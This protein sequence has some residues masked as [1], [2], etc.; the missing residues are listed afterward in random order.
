[1][2]PNVIIGGPG[3]A[4]RRAEG[5]GVLDGCHIQRPAGE[6]DAPPLVP[7]SIK[8]VARF[9]ARANT[10]AG[11]FEWAVGR[12]RRMPNRGLYCRAVAPSKRGRDGDRCEDS[13]TQRA[14]GQFNPMD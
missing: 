3:R 1:M 6:G 4:C 5:V 14:A 12:P 11:G 13:C 9:P 8:Q 7:L 2:F 10:S